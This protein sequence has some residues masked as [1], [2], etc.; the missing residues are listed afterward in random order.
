[1]TTANGDVARFWP[2]RQ[3]SEILQSGFDR[4]MD[5]A[6]APGGSIIFAEYGTGRILAI[7]GANVAELADGLDRPVGVAVA[8]EG[9]CYASESGGGRVVRINGGRVET[10]L[11]GLQQ[12]EGIVLHRD[13]LYVIDVGSRELITCDLASGA[14]TTIASNL[15]V[16]AP[17]GLTR[18]Q[19]GAVGTLSGPMTSFT[20]IASGPDGSIYVS[21]DAEGSVIA[22]RPQ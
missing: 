8:M 16:G 11:D 20:G 5:V 10:L 12:P 2:E 6:L 13:T 7:E 3:E 17:P 21:G 4:A 9:T 22:L 19:L 1:V 14:C 15:P 18:V